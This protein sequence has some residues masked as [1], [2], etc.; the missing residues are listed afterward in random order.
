MLNRIPGKKVK[1]MRIK[2][3]SLIF[4]QCLAP[5]NA[6]FFGLQNIVTLETYGYTYTW[7]MMSK[8][9]TA[10]KGNVFL[11]FIMLWFDTVLFFVVAFL[12]DKFVLDAELRMFAYCTNEKTKHRKQER[13]T[14]AEVAFDDLRREALSLIALTK[15]YSTTGITAVDGLNLHFE[16]GKTTVL[17]G[18]NG[19]GKSTL[20]QVLNIKY[21]LLTK[22]FNGGF[23][24]LLGP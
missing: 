21:Y 23:F 17:V 20:M 10:T 19:A 9:T 5:A 15:V 24:P 3:R 16:N 22:L 8:Y 1:C 6:L 12:F 14:I 4:F 7:R 11:P 13:E 18:K 2:L